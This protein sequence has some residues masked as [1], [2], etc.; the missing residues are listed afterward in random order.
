MIKRN[1]LLF[2]FSL[3]W[4][5]FLQKPFLFLNLKVVKFLV[6]AS[7]LINNFFFTACS[8]FISFTLYTNFLLRYEFCFFNP[9]SSPSPF[10]LT[11]LFWVPR[12]WNLKHK[13]NFYFILYTLTSGNQFLLKSQ[14]LE[15]QGIR[16]VLGI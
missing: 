16:V 12:F 7:T 15:K 14:A 3:A 5:L 10:K 13:L 1:S 4:S 6:V 11:S 9:S 2:Y 8:W